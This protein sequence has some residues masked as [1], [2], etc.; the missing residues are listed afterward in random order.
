VK[1]EYINPFVSAA[2]EVFSTMLKC[3][4]VRGPLSLNANFQPAH[5]VSGIIG[6]SGR[7]SGTVVVSVDREVAMSATEKFL[8]TRPE[9]IDSDVI[10]AIGEITNMIAGRAKAGLEALA[11]S[12][13]LPT[14]ITGK[15][16]T[17]RFGSNA[18]TICIPYTSPW[19]ELSV[20]VGLV[21][22]AEAADHEI[23][24]DSNE[25]QLAGVR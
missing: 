16:H 13:A 19:G 20:E 21:E 9:T 6:L 5:E 7:A 12:L 15:N 1:A 25:H 17:I 11:M 4:L 18:Q 2:V 22:S 24:A 14:V 3:D 23:A 10:D 8:G